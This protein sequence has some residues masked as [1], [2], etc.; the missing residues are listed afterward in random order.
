MVYVSASIFAL[1]MFMICGAFA[2]CYIKGVVPPVRVLAPESMLMAGGA[3]APMQ[4]LSLTLE[5]KDGKENKA[6]G[7]ALEQK[8]CVADVQA[9][10]SQHEAKVAELQAELEKL[11]AE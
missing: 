7:A 11:K 10:L 4:Q 6:S 8:R 5:G 2:Y 1:I 3:H 9:E